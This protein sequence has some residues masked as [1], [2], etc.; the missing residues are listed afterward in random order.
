MFGWLKHAFAVD[1]PGPATPS[2]LER[3]LIERLVEEL[4]RRRLTTPAVMMLECSRPLNYIGSQAMT[5]FGPIAELIFPRAE[6][7]AVAAFLE[8]RGSIEYICQ[9]L[10]AKDAELSRRRDG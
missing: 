6:Y 8:R 5:F 1:P 9:R 7:R 2:E 4:V 10:E 3:G